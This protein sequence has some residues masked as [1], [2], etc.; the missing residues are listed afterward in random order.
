MPDAAPPASHP[1]PPILL[2]RSVNLLAGSS[3]A[4]KT[5]LLAFLARQL[6]DG[7]GVLSAPAP[8]APP[9]QA[10]IGGADKSWEHSSSKWFG[11]EGVELPH[12]ALSDDRTFQKRRLR[13]KTDRI[14]ILHECLCKVAPNATSFP[15]GSVVYLDPGTL[16]LGGNL[17]DYD[18][19][20]VACAEIRELCQQMGDL[21]LVATVHAGKVKSD[22]KQG[23]ARLQDQILGSAGLFG[24]SD[25][26][27]FLASPQEMRAK[28]ATFLWSPH[29]A[30]EEVFQLGRG[31]TGR[32]LS[33]E[34]TEL[35]AASWIVKVLA[36]A[37][38]SALQFVDL[39]KEAI[40]RNLSKS[41]LHR[42]LDREIEAGRV[43][44]VGHGK[45]ALARKQ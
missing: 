12:Y 39:L 33:V 18:A 17:L 9:F 44:K 13:T 28:T 5:A 3:G 38:E 29:H 37:P 36:L 40:D 19:C 45:Y 21:C 4:G 25:T 34:D 8:S 20:A 11:L 26:Q 14:A 6:R 16:F 42:L 10:Y 32:F 30:Q 43:R 41:S 24:Y 35:E 2:A 31:K 15:R 23:Y 1:L 22:K 7:H 27:M